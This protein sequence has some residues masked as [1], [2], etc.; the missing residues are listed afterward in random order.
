M[1]VALD[2]IHHE[3]R[4]L[5]KGKPHPRT[6]RIDLSRSNLNPPTV[7]VFPC[8]VDSTWYEDHISGTLLEE[9]LEL[10]K[11]DPEGFRESQPPQQA[12]TSELDNVDDADR[13]SIH[14]PSSPIG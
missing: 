4:R 7:T 13:S 2:G 1:M 6:K 3:Q 14:Y 5:A 8:M 10:Y 12:A 9:D 11:E